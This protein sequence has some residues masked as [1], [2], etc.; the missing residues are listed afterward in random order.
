VF[1]RRLAGSHYLH[2][3]F[4]KPPYHR[5]IIWAMATTEESDRFTCLD[6][7]M[8]MRD[9]LLRNWQPIAIASKVDDFHP[10]ELL[11]ERNRVLS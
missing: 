6:S 5:G 10:T 8:P 1:T 9:V 11:F 3:A 2:N 7:E 4:P